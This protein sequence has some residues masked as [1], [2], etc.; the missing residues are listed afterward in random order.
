MKKRIFTLFIITAFVISSFAGFTMIDAA[1]VN[2]PKNLSIKIS[3]TN[4][5][6]IYGKGTWSPSSTKGV[7]YKWKLTISNKKTTKTY[8]GTTS[9][10]YTNKNGKDFFGPVKDLK[11]KETLVLKVQAVKNGK[12]SGWITKT[13][14]W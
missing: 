9:Q 3:D 2:P 7:K 8:S 12:G 14:T 5:S 11:G 4:D 10:C 13:K 6:S 1:K